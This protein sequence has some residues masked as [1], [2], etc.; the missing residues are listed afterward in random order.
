MA[1]HNQEIESKF[2]LRDLTPIET[3]LQ[4]LGAVCR[5]PRGF[6]YN[7]RYDNAQGSL[8]AE[9][10]VLRLRKFDDTR[11]TFKGPG[12]NIGGALSRTEIELIVDNFENARLLLE[13]LGY[14]VAVIYE[15]YRAIYEIE[16]ALVTL[17][18]L[19]YGKF[20]EIEAQNPVAIARLAQKLGLN[21]KRAI[22]ASY[23]GLFERIKQSRGLD[24]PHLTFA[25]FAG[26]EISPAEMGVSPA[27]EENTCG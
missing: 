26:L 23:Q 7:L 15:K 8:Q 20:I 22:P 6:E 27:D 2:Y 4:A 12:E 1:T 13:G 19:P 17:D 10:K 25:A 14:H 11:L 3:R 24:A 21:P 18:E 9:R 5:V 16:S